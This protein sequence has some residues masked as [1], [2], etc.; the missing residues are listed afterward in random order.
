MRISAYVQTGI[1]TIQLQVGQHRE[2]ELIQEVQH[3]MGNY[4]HD[5]GQKL[6][7]FRSNGRE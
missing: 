6:A 3:H 2:A 4:D 7:M 1:K 5:S